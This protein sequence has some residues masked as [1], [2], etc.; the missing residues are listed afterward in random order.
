[1]I[2]VDNMLLQNITIIPFIHEELV[3]RGASR[4]ITID[5]TDGIISIICDSNNAMRDF[6]NSNKF[7]YWSGLWNIPYEINEKRY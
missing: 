5:V 4:P 7:K 2:N 3:K 1:M 6:L